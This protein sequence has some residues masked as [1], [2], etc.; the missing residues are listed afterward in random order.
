MKYYAFYNAQGRLIYKT[1]TEAIC[2]GENVVELTKEKYDALNVEA[3][4]KIFD[5]KKKLSETDYI[6]CK[7]AE[8]AATT[9]EYAKV[10]AE[11][12]EWRE[13]INQLQGEA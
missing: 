11:R 2:N 7:I 8:G 1:E 6:A 5:L 9:S 4:Q 10:L 12:A 13:R 3:E